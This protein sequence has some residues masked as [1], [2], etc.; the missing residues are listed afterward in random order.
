M[1]SPKVL[2]EHGTIYRGVP[3]LPITTCAHCGAEDD[4]AATKH[5]PEDVDG[6]RICPSCSMATMTG[7]RIEQALARAMKAEGMAT[8]GELYYFNGLTAMIC[9]RWGEE[10]HVPVDQLE[11]A[12]RIRAALRAA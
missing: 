12:E 9:L 10:R 8:A 6:D 11:E 3:H 1:I 5:W 7:E 4:P 2:A